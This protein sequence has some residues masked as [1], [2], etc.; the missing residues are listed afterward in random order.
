M[1]KRRDDPETM[2]QMRVW[3]QE[4]AEAINVPVS[5]VTDV[6]VPLLALISE[7]AHG[8]S[9]PGAPLT[10]FLAGYAA[11]RGTNSEDAIAKLT[12]IAKGYPRTE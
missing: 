10:A 12:S 11:G 1:S 9:R 4:A 5:A 2:K 8:P 7:V 6:E 3:L